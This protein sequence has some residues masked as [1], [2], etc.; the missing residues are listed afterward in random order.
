MVSQ[1]TEFPEIK[2][3]AREWT[4]ELEVFAL[5]YGVDDDSFLTKV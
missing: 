2:M 3:T 4:L 5:C 1:I